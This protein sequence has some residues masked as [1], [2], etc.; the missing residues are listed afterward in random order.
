MLVVNRSAA[1]SE[2]LKTARSASGDELSWPG[3]SLTSEY[4]GE[5]STVKAISSAPHEALEGLPFKP[6][7]SASPAD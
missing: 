2:I 6:A 7:D 1:R 5:R 3:D 4:S